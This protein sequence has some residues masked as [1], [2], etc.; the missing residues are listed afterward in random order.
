MVRAIAAAHQQGS[1]A[2]ERTLFALH[3][4]VTGELVQLKDRCDMTITAARA[5]EVATLKTGALMRL[6]AE[7]GALT[8]G[9]PLDEA[10]R[11]GAVFEGLGV[12]FQVVDD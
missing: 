2:L 10:V 12:A 5:R 11:L 4:L 9:Y 7:L 1:A 3:R 8:A 6:C